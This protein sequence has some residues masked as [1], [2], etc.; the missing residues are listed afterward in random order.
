MAF[1]PLGDLEKLK[2]IVVHATLEACLYDYGPDFDHKPVSQHGDHARAAIAGLITQNNQWLISHLP[3][4]ERE[5]D[6][7]QDLILKNFYWLVKKS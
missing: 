4:D 1:A 2:N 7:C 5:F 3:L 6:D